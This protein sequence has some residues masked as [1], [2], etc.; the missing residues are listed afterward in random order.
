MSYHNEWGEVWSICRYGH[1]GVKNWPHWIVG[2]KQ[3]FHIHDAQAHVAQTPLNEGWRIF[4][5]PGYT[6]GPEDWVGDPWHWMN[7]TQ[8]RSAPPSGMTVHPHAVVPPDYVPMP[9][10]WR[11][12]WHWYIPECREAAKSLLGIEWPDA[13]KHQE[14]LRKV[15]ERMK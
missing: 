6:Y 2:S 10:H 12:P 14:I 4:H 11:G 3:I 8:P 1:G 15:R 5:V 13:G 9:D 7:R